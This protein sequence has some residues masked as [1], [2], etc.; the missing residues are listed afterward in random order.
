MLHQA[1]LSGSN[2]VVQ[3]AKILPPNL[4]GNLQN[5]PLLERHFIPKLPSDEDVVVGRLAVLEIVVVEVV[6]LLELMVVVVNVVVVCVG[7]TSLL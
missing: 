6:I 4:K 3:E 2:S 1:R 5:F 7:I